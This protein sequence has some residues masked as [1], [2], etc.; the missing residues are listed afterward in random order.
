M[1]LIDFIAVLAIY[2]EIFVLA[3]IDYK[4]WH[5]VYTPLN[6]LMLPY[7]L[8]L[9]V[10]LL[11]CGN[12][13]IVDFYYPSLL[14][15]MIGLILFAIPGILFGIGFRKRLQIEQGGTINDEEMN[16]RRLNVFST[17]LVVAFLLRFVYKVRTSQY[18]PGTE[19]F[20]YEFCGAGLWGHLHRVLHALSIIYI[21]KYDRKHWYYML[22][23]AGMYFVTLMYGVKSWVLIPAMG[24]I[25]M[26]LFAGKIKLRFSLFLKVA[27]LAFLVFFI[28][29]SFSLVLGQEHVATFDVIFEIIY[30]NFVHYV[31]SGIVGWSQDLEMG[32]L[33]S[34]RF[35]VL[36]TNVLN[37]YQAVAGNEYVDPVNPFFIHNG[38][39]GSNVRAFFGTIY[40]NASTIQFVL[41]VLAVSAIHYLV[42]IWATF[43]RHFYVNVVYFFYAGMLLMGWFEIYFYHLQFLEV[44]AMVLFIYIFMHLGFKKKDNLQLTEEKNE[45]G[46]NNT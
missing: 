10:A 42:K 39:K 1:T 46:N 22:L 23:I 21:Y 28:T 27:F 37:L 16:M 32:I 17:I 20:G 11:A 7:A 2:I 30:K 8:M 26:R 41:V 24:G 15:W 13:G 43:T 45:D 6:L 25:C 31:I 44:P 36:L 38:V 18:L 5:T 14:L 40:V 12:W 35:D 4:L 33:E 29:Y 9:M 3:V 34:P 19:D